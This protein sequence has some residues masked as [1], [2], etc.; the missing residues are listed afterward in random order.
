M[1][2]VY[3]III[4]ITYVSFFTSF[5]YSK[6]KTKQKFKSIHKEELFDNPIDY[7]SS[8]GCKLNEYCKNNL[9]NIDLEKYI[10]QELKNTYVTVSLDECLDIALKN[11]FD[12]EISYHEYKSSK[13]EYEYS[14][15]KFLPEFGTSSYIADYAGQILVGGVLNDKFHE[16]A[17][18]VNLTAQHRLTNGGEDI[19]RAKAAKY[20]EK[21]KKHS[22]NFTKTQTLY[23]TSRYYYEMLLAKINIEIYLRNLIER[24]AQ[25]VLTESLEQSGFGTHFDVV[26][27]KNES[28]D[29]KAKLLNA[30][31]QF[32]MSQ[33][34]LANIMGINVKTALMPFETDVG[35]LNLVEFDEEDMEKLFDIALKNREDLK[36]FKDLINYERQIKNVIITE[37]FP[38]PLVNFQQQFQGTMQTSIHPNYIVTG[39]I[40]WMPGE[41]LGVG[42]IAK[43]KAQK[44]KIE[45]KKLQMENLLRKISQN[46]I[47]STSTSKFNKSQ[48]E[49]NEKRMEYTKES[50][51]LA[52]LRFNHGKGILLDVIQAQNEMTLARIQY[53]SSV[54]NYNISQ[55]E[56]I[57]NLGTISKEEIVKNYNP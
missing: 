2:V 39:M 11:N 35:Q 22:Q 40:N 47:D 54:I 46:I 52:M 43:L 5:S 26:R 49:I 42:T 1:K 9:E 44:E 4:L 10:K 17:L 21:S 24:N 12:M 50:V 7:D 36:E 32:R 51:K 38:K 29:A 53:V 56:T 3:L 8:Q 18:S 6:E 31:N 25:L 34:R 55:L 30:L 13:F 15:S 20:F 16:T 33:S 27:A 19:F 57:Y 45:V 14:L 28:A 48:I 23:Y 37:F 41:S